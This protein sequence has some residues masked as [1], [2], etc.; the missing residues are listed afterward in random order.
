M[1]CQIRQA[2]EKDSE[3]IAVLH[4]NSWK[5]A[6]RSLLSDSYLDN[7]LEGERKKYW[8]DKMS[9][10]SEKEF[11]LVAENESMAIGFAALLDKPEMGYDA[12]IDNLHVRADMKG[13][14]IGKQLMKAVAERLIQTGRKSVY[15]FVLKGND[16]AEEFYLS[17]G[18][19]RAD[20][21][22]VEFGGKNVFHTRF[23][24]PTLDD[25][26]NESF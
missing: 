19:K 9:K 23:V 20:A 17:R 24:W 13:Q 6:Y 7:D 26:L 4:A 22:A 10:L 3:K 16:A 1:R 5:K 14:G 2:T 11:V 21:S 15:L 18:A 12:L 25:L 8:S